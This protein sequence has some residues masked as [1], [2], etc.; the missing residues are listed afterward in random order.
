MATISKYEYG[1]RAR[2]RRGGVSKTE[3][4]RTKAEATAWATQLEASI[5]SGRRGEVPN[6]PFK[7]LV[8]RYSEEVT[9]AKRG[10]RSELLRLNRTMRDPIADVPLPD[11][12]QTHVAAWRDRRLAHVGPAS[13]RREWVTLGHACN[14]AIREWRWLTINPFSMVGKPPAPQP[15]RRRPEG[16]EM[17]RILHELA[18]SES[19][20]IIT[21]TQAVGAAALFAIE[22]AMR[23]SEIARLRWC[24]I[25]GRVAHL[26]DTKNGDERHVP[27]SREAMRLLAR[28]P[29]KEGDEDRPAFGVEAASIDAI[30]RKAKARALVEGLNFHDLR[31]EALTRLSKKL[32]VLELAKMSGH[33]DL[34]ILL[35]V[36][37][38]PSPQDVAE[39]LD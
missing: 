20:P 39:M 3:T 12:D 8:A 7:D 24:D 11:L 15:R 6:R 14:I 35:Q 36:Y 34:R 27:L 25:A 22:T 29:R 32:P 1:W 19:A 38:A 4:F 2:V 9:P 37:Y 28:L 30:W 13:T 16:D 31:R 26:K 21:K 33:R 5:A 10:A 23:E 17:A 18:Y